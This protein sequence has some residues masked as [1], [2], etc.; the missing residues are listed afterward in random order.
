MLHCYGSNTA[1][2]ISSHTRLHARDTHKIPTGAFSISAGFATGPPMTAASTKLSLVILN[3]L[4]RVLYYYYYV[5]TIPNVLQRIDR[6]TKRLRVP[7]GYFHKPLYVVVRVKVLV[8]IAIIGKR[9]ERFVV[10]RS[11]VLQDH[12]RG[13]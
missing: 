7:Y 5:H 10:R 9:I 2:T 4:Y 11:T 6:P 8:F 12:E 1:V 3:H 13:S